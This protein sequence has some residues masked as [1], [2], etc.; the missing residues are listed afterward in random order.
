MK[1][2]FSRH[3][4]EKSSYTKLQENRPVGASSMRTDGQTD[5]TKLTVA[6]RNF[7]NAPKNHEYCIVHSSSRVYN[8]RVNN[9]DA[10]EF[11]LHCSGVHTHTLTYL[12]TGSVNAGRPRNVQM[13]AND[14]AT[15]AAVEQ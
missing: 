15:T 11:V 3:I 12:A 1:L 14:G 4:F 10:Q 7:A 13:P 6:F 9:T 8:N 2:E 5:M